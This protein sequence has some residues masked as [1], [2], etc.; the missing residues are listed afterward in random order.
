QYK[1]AVQFPGSTGLSLRDLHKFFSFAAPPPD[2]RKVFDL[3]EVGLYF[4]GL[5]PQVLRPTRSKQAGNRRASKTV[6]AKYKR[7]G[8]SPI[9]KRRAFGRSK[10]FHTSGGGAAKTLARRIV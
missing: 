3:P 5:R 8:H 1:G 9:I 2:V 10:T 6:F 4:L 7:E